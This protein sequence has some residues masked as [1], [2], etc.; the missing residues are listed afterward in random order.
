M[1]TLLH[2]DIIPKVHL[3]TAISIN[4]WGSEV[5]LNCTDYSLQEK[6][7]IGFYKCNSIIFSIYGEG[8][9]IDGMADIIGLDLGEGQ[10][11]KPAVVHTDLFEVLVSYHQI[12]IQRV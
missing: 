9:D 4:H 5:T 6:I 7:I 8:V 11:K 10:Y 12:D 1:E 2:N 3:V